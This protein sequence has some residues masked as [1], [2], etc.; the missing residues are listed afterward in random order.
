MDAVQIKKVLLQI[1]A[2]AFR[3][4]AHM[5]VRVQEALFGRWNFFGCLVDSGTG[6][7]EIRFFDW[8]EVS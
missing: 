3:V 2:S 1:G 4:F 8:S 7:V 5:S 6:T